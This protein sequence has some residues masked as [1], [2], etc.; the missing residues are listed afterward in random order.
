MR[1]LKR[2]LPV[3][4]AVGVLGALAFAVPASATTTGACQ[5]NGTAS[6]NPS[7]QLSGG[8][9]SYSFDTKVQGS[10]NLSFRCVG[11]SGSAAAAGQ[12][13]VTSKGTYS[14]NVC[15]TGSASSG[16]AGDNAVSGTPNFVGDPTIA[17]GFV[18]AI[19]NVKYSIGFN[20]GQ[21]TF[22]W[23]TGSSISRVS[24]NTSGAD[25]VISITAAFNHLNADGTAGTPGSANFQGGECTDQFTVAG[26]ITGQF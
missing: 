25:G 19:P 10:G 4:F 7:V 2:L 13:D 24:Q 5:V 6:T 18:T 21:G 17:N 26:A 9:G 11:V 8:S 12:I 1:G 15:G 20:A 14:N 3:S 16:A 23:T 22:T